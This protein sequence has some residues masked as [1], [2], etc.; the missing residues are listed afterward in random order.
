[1]VRQ[2]QERCL[3]LHSQDL[4]VQSQSLVKFR[5]AGHYG[6]LDDSIAK[7][8]APPF[9]YWFPLSKPLN[10]TYRYI[11][12]IIC[13]PFICSKCRSVEHPFSCKVG[14]LAK[15]CARAGL[16]TIPLLSPPAWTPSLQALT[17]LW[18]A[19]WSMKE[20]FISV[21]I[22][23]SRIHIDVFLSSCRSLRVPLTTPH[24]GWTI[25]LVM[26]S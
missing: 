24:V 9:G 4:Q 7:P 20:R 8:T 6:I 18:K 17:F 11:K 16:A 22:F 14:C 5:L 12:M 10:L 3:G 25:L 21:S 15:S 1:M 2:V 26:D 13:F 19:L 23:A